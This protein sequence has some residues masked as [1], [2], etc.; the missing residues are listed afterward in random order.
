MDRESGEAVREDPMVWMSSMVFTAAFALSPAGAS[1]PPV[2]HPAKAPVAPA[3]LLASDA[4]RIRAE[5]RVMKLLQDGV[6]RS[7]TFADL[8]AR[9]HAT[10]LIVYVETSSA[11]RSDTLG[12]IVLQAVAGGQRYLRVQVKS[13]L[14]GDQMIAVIAHE[15]RHALE[16]AEDRSVVD[17]TTLE[18][19]YR[20]I[21]HVTEGRTGFD[22]HE[23][24]RTGMRVRDEL[25]G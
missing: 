20:R 8:V 22:T 19:L 9:V 10:D 24:Q 14:H 4:R 18:R 7:T 21:G 1:L 15:L 25:I 12:R 11:L 17:D 2:L 13:M 3:Q 5:K 23:A 16:V 6:R